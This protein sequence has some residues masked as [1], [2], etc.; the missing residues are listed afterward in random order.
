VK[1]LSVGQSRDL[2]TDSEWARE[3]GEKGR[4]GGDSITGDADYH[5]EVT[6]PEFLNI[7]GFGKKIE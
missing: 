2:K 4:L 1:R 6:S 5:G 3:K 7:L